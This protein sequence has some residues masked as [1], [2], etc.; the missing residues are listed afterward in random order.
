MKDLLICGVPIKEIQS[1]QLEILKEFD[2]VCKECSIEYVLYGGTLLGAIRHGGFIPWDDDIDV[3]MRRDDYEKFLLL[4]PDLLDNGFFLQNR[5]SDQ[6]YDRRYAKIRK[7]GTVFIEK[8][9]EG[10]KI[11]HGLFIDVFPLDRI[12]DNN[13][14]A[15]LHS[16]I[17]YYLFYIDDHLRN[18]DL[19][20][21]YGNRLTFVMN[22]IVHKLMTLYVNRQTRRVAQI[23]NSPQRWSKRNFNQNVCSDIVLVEYENLLVPIPRNYHKI[24]S[25]MYGDYQQPPPPEERKTNHSLVKVDLGR[26]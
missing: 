13:V 21:P 20:I 6:G 1:V 2:R 16:F 18:G 9:V 10:K 19:N 24:L 17:L 25:E 7:D 15:G 5:F 23:C 8:E 4:A 3:A 14:I 11:H 22:K 12:S 26:N